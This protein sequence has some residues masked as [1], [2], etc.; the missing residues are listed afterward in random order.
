MLEFERRNI[1]DEFIKVRDS[2]EE[3]LLQY[4]YLISQIVTRYRR[5]ASRS[6]ESIKS[7]YLLVM[8]K[9][10]ESKHIDQVVDEIIQ[11]NNFHY[12]VKQVPRNP[13]VNNDDFSH[14]VK[15]VVCQ[16]SIIFCF[17]V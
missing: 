3:L 7:I 15:R 5:S 1:Y 11:M 9:L 10:K 2:F 17:K 6:F 8:Q 12:L 13:V 14:D 16:R 4:N